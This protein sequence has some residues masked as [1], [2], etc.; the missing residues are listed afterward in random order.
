MN[1]ELSSLAV[2]VRR[3]AVDAA[4]AAYDSHSSSWNAVEAKAQASI[5]VA[6]IFLAGAFAVLA[7]T[8]ELSSPEKALLT[9]ACV[10]LV[11]SVALSIASLWPRRVKRHPLI[12]SESTMDLLNASDALE[13]EADFWGDRQEAWRIAIRGIEK[14]LDS[15]VFW[16]VLAHGATATATVL[17]GVLALLLIW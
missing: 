16:L 11:A 9:G 1:N 15:K 5:A 7:R 2:R 14:A 12:S 8:A 4:R 6:G 13:S 3:D 10:A 17:F